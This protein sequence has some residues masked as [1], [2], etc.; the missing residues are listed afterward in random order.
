MPIE[1]TIL[2]VPGNVV[3]AKR[4][5]RFSD[6]GGTLGRGT[7]NVWVLD[8][9][10][11]YMSSVHAEIAYQSGQYVLIDLSTNGTY[12]NAAPEPIGRSNQVLLSEQDR[13][14]ISDYEFLVTSITSEGQD[15]IPAQ[16]FGADP[17]DQ[18]PETSVD[19]FDFGSASP[20]HAAIP[21]ASQ[22]LDIADNI[23]PIDNIEK[24]PLVALELSQEQHIEPAVNS[25][26]DSNNFD[27]F[28]SADFNDGDYRADSDAINESIEWP[29]MNIESGQIPDD[30]DLDEPMSSVAV[31][32]MPVTPAPIVPTPRHTKSS[33]SPSPQHDDFEQQSPSQNAHIEREN[34]SLQNENKRL[35]DQVKEL[36]QQ[37][38][39]SQKTTQSANDGT[40]VDK[41]IAALG[42]AHWNLDSEKKSHIVET[43]GE[44]MPEVMDGM[45]RVLK[46]R[47]QIK[48]EFRINVTT[49]QSVENNPLKFSA[50]VEDAMENMFIK[51][52]TAYKK[53]IAAVREGFEGIAEHQLAVIAGMQAAFKGMLDRF[54]PESLENR[55]EKYKSSSFVS[56]GQKGKN[57]ASYK[58][59]HKGLIEN[60]DDSFQ[61]LFGYDFVQAYEEQMQHLISNRI[62][63]KDE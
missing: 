9:P 59:Y 48:E 43:M 16:V 22:P 2:N 62:M 19:D 14:T 6:A 58:E 31:A 53:P 47:K 54:E 42:L 37:L 61:H 23:H 1:I 15:D 3:S 27:D 46:F 41:L 25:N 30:W 18:F 26:F 8:D 29:T 12:F 34:I 20:L 7:N 4:E 32:A 60:L 38:L 56:F 28:N 33:I 36:Q 51:N 10:E 40:E 63:A 57:W 49:I 11:K 5:H 21:A 45:M 44:L 13:F 35:S 17:F 24:D 52:N 39:A 50:N 55:F